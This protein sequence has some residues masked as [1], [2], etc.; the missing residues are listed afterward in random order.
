[1]KGAK[2]GKPSQ[3]GKVP[4]E[5]TKHGLKEQMAQQKG[6]KKVMMEEKLLSSVPSLPSRK[7]S[8]SS[9]MV[10]SSPTMVPAASSSLGFL[11]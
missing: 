6:Q 9:L 3:E 2:N 11:P 5:L 8:W 4:S 10:P 7:C 1:M